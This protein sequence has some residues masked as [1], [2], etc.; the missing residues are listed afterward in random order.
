M[1]PSAALASRM[2]A[3]MSLSAIAAVTREEGAENAKT[4]AFLPQRR[5][6]RRE[7]IKFESIMD[8]ILA[9]IFLSDRSNI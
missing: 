6:E 9:Q 3:A 5:K 1:S 2:A 4:N 7:K 8:I